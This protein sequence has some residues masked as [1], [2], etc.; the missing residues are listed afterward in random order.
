MEWIQAR[1]GGTVRNEGR[2]TT[3]QKPVWRWTARAS[4]YD[5]LLPSLLPYLV[6]KKQQAEL[7]IA[8]RKTVAAKVRTGRATAKT[9]DDTKRERSRIHSELVILNRRGAA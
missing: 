6:I 9:T 4:E 1:F 3:R 2:Q 8:Y 5:E 7:F